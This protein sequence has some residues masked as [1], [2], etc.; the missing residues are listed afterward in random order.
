MKVIKRDGSTVDFDRSKIVIAIQ[1]A[2]QAVDEP[3][4]LDEASIDAIA[5]AVA[6]KGRQRLLV[7]DIQDITTEQLT[8][9]FEVNVF[10]LFWI[11]KEALPHLKPGASIITCSSIQAYQPGKNLVDY[12]S[13][14]AA[15]IAFSRALAKQVASKGIRV[16]VV[17]PGPIWTA[18]QVTGG[19]LQKDL[20]EF[21]Q[22]TPLK[23]AGQ[24]VELSGLYVFLASQESSFITAEVF[25][26]TGGMHLA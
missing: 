10:S 11:A 20:P 12:A 4:R 15:I 25:G 3:Y 16:N 21:G 13:T 22:K 18:L 17:A 1:K 7:E 6:T 23:R 19:Q 2:N 14:K 8:K 26:V 5:D 24:P 9:T